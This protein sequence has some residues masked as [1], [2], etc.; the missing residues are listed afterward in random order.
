MFYV[1]SEVVVPIAEVG[2][3]KPDPNVDDAPA[4]CEY[5]CKQSSRR[6]NLSIH[7]IM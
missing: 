2:H 3:L 6:P 4:H 1:L 5:M 7:C